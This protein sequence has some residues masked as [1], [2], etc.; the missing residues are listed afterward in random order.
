MNGLGHGGTNL[1]WA[2]G[3]GLTEVLEVT[4]QRGSCRGR[5]VHA[6]SGWFCLAFSWGACFCP[7][8]NGNSGSLW[9]TV[10]HA[11]AGALSPHQALGSAPLMLMGKPR[12]KGGN[13][14]VQNCAL[15]PPAG[16]CGGPGVTTHS[17]CALSL[18]CPGTKTS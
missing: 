4:Q 6:G 5:R 3:R 16:C 1:G 15:R 13:P 9:P 14:G 2:G 7:N 11:L 17:I 8:K 10:W 12:S 18:T